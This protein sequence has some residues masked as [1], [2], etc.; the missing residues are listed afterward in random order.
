[1]SN[2]MEGAG[3]VMVVVNTL[4]LIRLGLLPMIFFGRNYRIY[5]K[6]FWVS[7]FVTFVFLTSEYMLINIMIN[8]GNLK[9]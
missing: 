5:G 1:M 2:L 8:F 9:E 3:W 4:C 7:M 6:I